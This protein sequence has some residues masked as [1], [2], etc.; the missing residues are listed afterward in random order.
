VNRFIIDG[1]NLAYRAHYAFNKFSTSGGLPSGGLYGFFT[2]LRALRKRF[3][4]FKFFVVWDNEAIGKKQIFSEYKANREV[5]RVNLPIQDLKRALQCLN[6]TQVECAC[7]EADDVIATLV[8]Q[9]N[10]GK[11]YIYSSDKDLQQLVVDGKIIIVSPKVGNIAEKF[12]DEENVKNK[13]GVSPQDLPCFL[14]FRGDTSDNVP[15]VPRV[16]SNVLA[17]LCSKY[18]LPENVYLNLLEEKLT[19]FQRKSLLDSQEQV[20]INYSLILL[21]KDLTCDYNEGKSNNEN[22]KEI[23]RKYEIKALTSEG[24]VELFDADTVFLHREGPMLKTLSLFDEE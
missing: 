8:T 11:D 3:S 16:P 13:W 20:K 22:L 10:T 9:S 24:L 1:F 23:L 14:A 4:D 18:K 19:D 2:T 15:G 7:E 5:F 12:Y 21:K 6:I 17:S